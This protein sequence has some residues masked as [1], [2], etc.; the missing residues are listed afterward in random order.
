MSVK[1]TSPVKGSTVK[2]V[3]TIRV[4][5][6]SIKQVSF[7][8]DGVLKGKDQSAPFAFDWYTTRYGDGTH[9]IKAVSNNG[10][11]SDTATYVVANVAPVPTPIPTPTTTVTLT[12]TP[13]VGKTLTGKIVV[14]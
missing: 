3:V 2:G 6:P 7:Y 11:F 12:G 8:V 4:D 5:A 13:Q 1:I 14:S 10:K 9:V